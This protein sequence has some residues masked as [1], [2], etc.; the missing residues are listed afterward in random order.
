MD[1]IRDS[2]NS[3]AL[4]KRFPEVY[5]EFFSKCQ[6][7]VSAP[8]FFTWAGEYVGYWGGLMLLQKLPLRLY[9]GLEFLPKNSGS[10]ID[11]DA[12]SQSYSLRKQEF[13]PDQ[14]DHLSQNRLAEFINKIW[15]RKLRKQAFRIHLLSEMPFGGSGSSG[16]LCSALAL[17]FHLQAR[18]V[19]PQDLKEWTKQDSSE[20]IR[21]K[22][23]RFDPV[24]RS[25]WKMLAAHRGAET[26]GATLFATLLPS[27]YPLYYL[28]K[29]TKNLI[30]PFNINDNYDLIDEAKFD[31]GRLDELFK[32][33]GRRSWPIDFGLLYL[34]EPRGNTPFSTL[35]LEETTKNV[36]DFFRQNFPRSVFGQDKKLWNNSCLEV[37]NFLSGDV[38][39]KFGT[40]LKGGHRTDNLREFLRAVD[41]HQALFLLLGLL[42]DTT[43]AVNSI[44]HHQA[45]KADD[46]GA[47]VKAV[48]T[49]K[50]DIVLFVFPAGQKQEILPDITATL[51]KEFGLE[52]QLG[53][54]SWIDGIEERGAV[55]EQFLGQKIYS[56]FVSKNTVVV[57]E[58]ASG[59]SVIRP[60]S[61]EQFAA[62]KQKADIL[63][64]EKS[65]RILIKGE[66]LTSA[67]LHSQKTAI[68]ILKILLAKT[69]Q[70]VSSSELPPSSY[71]NDRY[72]LQGKIISPLIKIIARKTKK[73][74]ALAI[75]GGI[76][77]FY[78]KLDPDN[79]TIWLVK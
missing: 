17:A 77:D 60:L 64:M 32:I 19:Y 52:V 43:G 2:L 44:I 72:E 33:S 59:R 31:G 78:L 57:Q 49:T 66:S 21:N 65:G 15:G 11:F 46:L 76:S 14:Y 22:K 48:S 29:E 79:L 54:G 30:L 74:L 25:A 47:G 50:K 16:A 69:N 53:Y 38:L 51:R 61:P 55:V 45:S 12:A 24:F 26:S 36:A 10:A 63:I 56:E 70:E 23:Y 75:R 8:H 73:K 58:F 67:Q 68:K 39:L 27:V 34:G 18:E 13:Q 9:V 5:R 7:V 1:K 71:A 37:M 3:A 4:K 62:Q 20:L 6:I 35:P 40:L 28:I 42:S 41:R